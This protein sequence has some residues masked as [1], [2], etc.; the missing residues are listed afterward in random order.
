MKRTNP[1]IRTTATTLRQIKSINVW[2]VTIKINCAQYG[3][4]PINLAEHE[5]W[6]DGTAEEYF[7]FQLD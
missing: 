6:K 2:E 4:R 3:Y 5:N 1:F 7:Q